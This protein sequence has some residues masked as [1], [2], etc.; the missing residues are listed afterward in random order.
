MRATKTIVLTVAMMT[1]GACGDG[2]SSGDDDSTAVPDARDE[3]PDAAP[4]PPP[5]TVCL[6][7]RL[8][9]LPWYDGNLET[10]QGWID[11][12]GCGSDD[13]D[14]QHKP[15]ALFDWDN[16]V[17]KGDVGDAITFW[18]IANGKVRQPPN[19]D[20]HETSPFLT[21]DAAAALVAA[22]GTSVAAGEPLPTSTDT[23]CA[24]EILSVYINSKTS[25]N[26]AAFAGHDYRTME[27]AYAWT[28]QLLAG[29]TKAEIEDYASQAITQHLAAAQ[30]ATWTV[31][32][33]SVAGWF[34]VYDQIEDLIGVMQSAGYDV[35]VISAS[36]QPVVEAFAPRVGVAPDHV[37]GIHQLTDAQ[38]R[39]TYHF[40]GCGTVADGD[41]TMISYI[42]GKRCWVNKVVF[43]D[44][45][46]AAE[47]RRP[48]GQRQYFGA[49]D[50]D[51]DVEFLRD[52]TYKLAINRN[53]SELMCNA[54]NNAGDS[55]AI[56]PMFISPKTQAPDYPC[57]TAAC[58][59]SAGGYVACTDEL[60]AAIPVQVDVVHE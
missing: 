49:G 55:W 8:Q 20:W 37:I 19:Q 57:P 50:S 11:A 60:S 56:N 28:A 39:Y 44:T 47:Q 1:A 42:G 13:Y 30:G 35:W 5:Q 9:D 52:A 45:T 43:G 2:G 40:E 32:T 27:P 3:Q 48:D 6:A 4:P 21:D 46:P 29:Y 12:A 41:D 59:D 17:I 54:Y 34:R 38:G 18:M 24:D 10:L 25:T 51:T 31:G 16:T 7:R 15:V 26:L 22:C 36:P 53:K 58:K 33:R 23:V 14:P